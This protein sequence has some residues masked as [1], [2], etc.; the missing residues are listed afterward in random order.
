MPTFEYP[1]DRR[2]RELWAVYFRKYEPVVKAFMDHVSTYGGP[3]T[4]QQVE[5][6]LTPFLKPLIIAERVKLGPNFKDI[7]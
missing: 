2:D 4:D 1:I 6:L 5:R 3:M 7:T